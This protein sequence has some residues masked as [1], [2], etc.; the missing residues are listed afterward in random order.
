[1]IELDI[2]MHKDITK[3][4][5]IYGERVLKISM[6][7]ISEKLE[8]TDKTLELTDDEADAFVKTILCYRKRL[9]NMNINTINRNL[10]PCII[11]N[12]QI[13]NTLFSTIMSQIDKERI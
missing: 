2:K 7:S 12:L 6:S 4:I 1:M 3:N 11:S 5:I 10:I 9:M 13:T 8:N